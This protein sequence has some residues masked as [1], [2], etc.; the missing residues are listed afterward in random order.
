VAYY[1]VSR[2]TNEESIPQQRDWAHTVAA[3]HNVT[4]LAEFEDA[5]IS[6]TETVKRQDFQAMLAYCQARH[7][8]RR[9]VRCIV[10]WTT[11][12]FSRADSIE[13]AWY[14]QEFRKVGVTMLLTAQGFVRFDKMEDR[15]L[16]AIGQDMTNHKYAMEVAQQSLRGRIQKAREG[17]WNGGPC[18]YGLR[19]VRVLKKVRDAKGREK[20]RLVPEKLE[21]DPETAP[22]L[23][24]LFEQY[25]TGTVSLWQ[26]AVRLNKQKVRP[27][28]KAKLWNPTTLLKILG[29]DLYLG[30]AVWN[31]RRT[32]KFFC[33][34]NLE[35]APRGDDQRSTQR[36]QEQDHIRGALPLMEEPLVPPAVF[37]LVQKR[38]RQ[39][40]KQTTPRHEHDFRLTGLL[41]CAAC[42]GRMVGRHKPLRGKH[43]HGACQRLFLCGNYA[44]HG[45][46]G[47]HHNAI[48]E[49]PLFDAIVRKVRDEYLNPD[50]LA[51]LRAIIRRKVALA[52]SA[53]EKERQ[54]LTERLCD[55]DGM[56]SKAASRLLTED[57]TCILKACREELKKLADDRD[58]T[59][60]VLLCLPSEDPEADP[61]KIVDEAMALMHRFDE[62]LTAG[63][64]AAVRCLLGDLLEKV[65]VF[66]DHQQ[67]SRGVQCTFAKALVYLREEAGV[68]SS[69]LIT[70]IRD[71][72]P[73]KSVIL[74]LLPADLAA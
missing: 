4:L 57:D 58:R 34:V 7:R 52:P 14:I 29:N 26:L 73:G 35:A 68:A 40:Q 5:A 23:V 49:E 22:V 36:N 71:Q 38:L 64:P 74:T 46:Q 21:P 13:T 56:I 47:C 51:R 18:P 60:Q 70:S 45:R 69:F 19:V 61:E 11:A 3:K 1:R 42:D 16:F 72:P 24:S 63:E 67:G 43:A 50:A 31:R 65:E 54:R 25:A 28:G 2:A 55:L 37:E 20:T 41:R 10:L 9:S 12:R 32:G 66:F 44:R 59:E 8:E 53:T 48:Y 15:V 39:R 30:T 6:G 27:P 33:A 62:V 17:G